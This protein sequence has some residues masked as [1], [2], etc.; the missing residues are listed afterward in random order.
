MIAS[1]PR[2][3]GV[4][5][6]CFALGA[7]NS[8]SAADGAQ[9]EAAT[10]STVAPSTGATPPAMPSSVPLPAHRA[11]PRSESSAASSET[12]GSDALEQ[13]LDRLEKEIQSSPP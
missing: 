7:C 5:L 3:S 12:I 6:L 9:R 8:A 4:A 13:R 11:P 10:R 2:P 1:L